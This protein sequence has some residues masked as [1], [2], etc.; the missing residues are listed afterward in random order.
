MKILIKNAQIVDSTSSH[1]GKKMDVLVENETILKIAKKIEDTEAFRV[2]G[3]ELH[4]S[5]GWTDLKASFCDPGDEH[6]ETIETGLDAAAFGG[7]THVAVLPSTNPVVDNKSSVE[8]LYKRAENHATMIH[9][10]GALTMGMKGENLSEMY[11]L[12]QTGV[13]LFSDDN[14]AVS[15][16]ILYR[17]LL[18]AKNFGGRVICF[19]RDASLA[20]KGMVN[21][22]LAS[23]HTGLK[24][25]PHIAEIIQV[26]RNIRLAEYTG[27]A[28]HFSGLSCT[29]SVDLIRKAKKNKLDITADVHVMNLLFTEENMFDFEAHYKVL[30]VLRTE[31]DRQALW[32]GLSDGTI[33]TIVS[34]HRPGDTEEKEI[35]FDHAAFGELQLQTTF[36]ALAEDSHFDVQLYCDMLGRKA[37]EIAGIE[38]STIEEG[39]AADLTIFSLNDPWLFSEENLISKTKNSPFLGR[40]FKTKT[41]AVINNGKMLINEA[42]YGEA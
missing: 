24:A 19:A 21:E 26:E 39:Q 28:L 27:G 23:V 20:G 8:Y 1:N 9:P 31:K 25:D 14:Q 15:A 41:L 40:N 18:Y 38:P 33:D 6:K 12:Y 2:E 7:Y 11:D 30:P 13:R 29:E 4:V 16:G 22:G 35:E 36:A 3:K 34:D 17:A 42:V 5:I 37:R 32:K 10:I